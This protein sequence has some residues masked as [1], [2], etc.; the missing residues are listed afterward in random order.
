MFSKKDT[1]RKLG[2][3]PDPV[4]ADI[5]AGTLKA[6]GIDCEV[7][8]TLLWSAAG[9]LPPDICAPE[10]WLTDARNMARARSILKE[11]AENSEAPAWGAR[12]AAKPLKR[13]SVSAGSAQPLSPQSPNAASVPQEASVPQG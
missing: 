7:R 11:I 8:N 13:S 10:I 3:W 1:T 4:T 2:T 5:A 6:S 9:E 12:T